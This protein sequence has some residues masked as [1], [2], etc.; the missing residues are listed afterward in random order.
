MRRTAVLSSSYSLYSRLMQEYLNKEDLMNAITEEFIG[1][2][3]AIGVDV[4]KLLQNANSLYLLQ[5]ICG[6]GI[7]KAAAMIRFLKQNG[8]RFESRAML[9][10]RCHMGPNIFKNCA[11]FLKIDSN[12]ISGR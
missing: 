12:V 8:G 9:I 11:G 6:L 10:S 3:N 1:A 7:C 4:N 5:F 2:V